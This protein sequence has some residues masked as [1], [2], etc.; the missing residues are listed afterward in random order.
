MVKVTLLAYSQWNPAL[1]FHSKMGGLTLPVAHQQPE[2][3]MATGKRICQT[4]DD[5]NS[6]MIQKDMI[7]DRVVSTVKAGHRG[8]L[9]HITFTFLIEGISRIETHQHVRHRM[10]SYLQMSQRSVD[11]LDL[12][13]ITPPSVRDANLPPT[14]R[15]DIEYIEELSRSVY[16]RLQQQGIERGD[17]RYYL[18]HGWET[19]IWMTVNGSAL[20]HFLKERYVGKG[21]QWEIREVATKMYGLAKSV[22]PNAFAEDLQEYWE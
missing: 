16:E 5:L 15:H 12:E 8:V 11:A 4:A 17:A 2:H 18:L 6:I 3:I 21:A 1:R 13:F 10:A 20:M 7:K 14:L 22:C 9:E 19:R